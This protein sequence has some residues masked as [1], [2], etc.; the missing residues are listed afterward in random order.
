MGNIY[1]HAITI[2]KNQQIATVHLVSSQTIQNIHVVGNSSEFG[3]NKPTPLQQQE[4]DNLL[5]K[6]SDIFSKSDKD[7]GFFVNNFIKLTQ[8]IIN[9][10]SLAHIKNPTLKKK[11]YPLKYLS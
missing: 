9:L 5:K 4:L 6:F 10:L 11:L 1:K 7:F 3:L 2:K 8:L